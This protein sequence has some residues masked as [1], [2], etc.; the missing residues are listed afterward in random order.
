MSKLR[1]RLLFSIGILSLALLPLPLDARPGGPNCPP[2]QGVAAAVSSV[3]RH[4]Y[5]VFIDSGTG[6]GY[7]VNRPEVLRSHLGHAI[8]LVAHTNKHGVLIIHGDVR[9]LKHA[10]GDPAV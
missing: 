3:W 7:R 10:V 5:I 1:R 4:P 9:C 6:Q 8:T 2:R